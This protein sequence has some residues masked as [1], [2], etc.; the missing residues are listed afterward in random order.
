MWAADAARLFRVQAGLGIHFWERALFKLEFV[1]QSEQD[2]SPGRIGAD[3]H[4]VS[5][6]LSIGF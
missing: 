5:T 3:W 4:G 6:E 1:N 2:S